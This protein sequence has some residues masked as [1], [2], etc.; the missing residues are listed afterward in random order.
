MLP[1]C[2][3]PSIVEVTHPVGAGDELRGNALAPE[4]I[5]LIP[6]HPK[7]PSA[8]RWIRRQPA[9]SPSDIKTVV[10]ESALSECHRLVSRVYLRL[11]WIPAVKR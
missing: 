6:M 1:L 8:L 7:N 5:R 11:G 4:S 3:P 10:E 2:N 9:V